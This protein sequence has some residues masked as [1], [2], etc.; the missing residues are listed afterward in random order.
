MAAMTRDTLGGPINVTGAMEPGFAVEALRYFSGWTDKLSGE[1]FPEEDVFFKLVRQEPLG[2]VSGIIPWNAPIGSACA[3][4]APALSTGNCFILKL[5]EKTPFA[6]LA[7]GS[8]AKAAEFPPGVLQVLSGDG[9]TGAIIANHMRLRKVSFTGSTATGK[10]I[11]EMAAQSDLKRVTLELGGKGPA[12]VFGDAKIKNTVTWSLV[13]EKTKLVGDPDDPNSFVG[14]VVD[15]S[16]F[17][18]AMGFIK[19]GNSQ[20]TV[21]VGGNRVH[22][23]GCYVASTVFTDVAE[24]AEIIRQEILV[25]WL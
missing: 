18:R 10:E 22:D 7:M 17:N 24:D 25:Q 5:S 19:R 8:L 16:Q 15:E 6:D 2:V 12:L 13:E 1:T 23:K 4:A 21:L 14:P 20:G 11:Q 9:S 3:K